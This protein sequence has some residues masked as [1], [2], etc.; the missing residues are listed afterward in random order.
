[1]PNPGPP[2]SAVMCRRLPPSPGVR[3]AVADHGLGRRRIVG[4]SVQHAVDQRNA[5]RDLCRMQV[6]TTVS[7]F[8]D[9]ERR[10][11]ALPVAQR[12][13]A[14][15]GALAGSISV[16]TG[17]NG[18]GTLSVSLGAGSAALPRQI[19]FSVTVAS[20]YASTAIAVWY[21]LIT[22]HGGVSENEGACVLRS[23]LLGSGRAT[24][25]LNLGEG[26]FLQSCSPR[27]W[28]SG[29]V[30][31]TQPRLGLAGIPQSPG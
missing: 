29:P 16:D 15:F 25:G 3:V 5:A 22:G 13:A 6:L 27:W 11:I 20:P 7:R 19:A 10:Q 24:T 12:S 8:F 23:T 31:P 14:A 2:D 1:M 26:G 4:G 28:S 21:I 17:V 18:Q 30:V 9:E